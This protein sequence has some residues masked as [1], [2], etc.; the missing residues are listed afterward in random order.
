MPPDNELSFLDGMQDPN[1]APDGTYAETAAQESGLLRRMLEARE[2]IGANAVNRQAG[3]SQQGIV[4][5]EQAKTRALSHAE[6]LAAILDSQK[7][8]VVAKVEQQQVLDAQILGQR[9]TSMM[10]L[11]GMQTIDQ[12]GAAIPQ[13]MQAAKIAQARFDQAQKSANPIMEGL[14]QA[15][16]VKTD[17]VRA[18]E[19]ADAI[20]GESA[21]LQAD[22]TALINQ[23]NASNT[24]ANNVGAALNAATMEAGLLAQKAEADIQLAKLEE[25]KAVVGNTAWTTVYAASKD[26]LSQTQQVANM[27]ARHEIGQQSVAEKIAMFEIR[28]QRANQA[29]ELNQQRFEQ[30]TKAWEARMASAKTKEERDALEFQMKQEL[31]PYKLE[32]ARLN[33]QKTKG[34]ISKQLEQ[35]SQRL[36]KIAGA[37]KSSIKQL[38]PSMNTLADISGMPDANQQQVLAYSEGLI[39]QFEYAKEQEALLARAAAD[40][41]VEPTEANQKK[42]AELTSAVSEA[43][44]SL[45]VSQSAV[46]QYQLDMISKDNEKNNKWRVAEEQARN[47][48]GIPPGTKFKVGSPEAA[49]LST[50]TA[51][52]YNGLP[53]ATGAKTLIDAIALDSVDPNNPYKTSEYYS[54]TTRAL[55][56]RIDNAA[57]GY[58][59]ANAKAEASEAVKR[60]VERDLRL[61]SLGTSASGIAALPV[62]MKELKE[63][64]TKIPSLADNDFMKFV[65]NRADVSGT[66]LMQAVEDYVRGESGMASTLLGYGN[67]GT[68]AAFKA[69]Q[70]KANE[71]A[72]ALGVIYTTKLKESRYVELGIDAPPAPMVTT[73]D[74]GKF[75]LSD[76]ASLQEYLAKSAAIRMKPVFNFGN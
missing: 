50:T 63:V 23:M 64:A 61:N 70:R 28:E 19:E 75:I 54:A 12:L 2:A 47:L 66:S 11:G 8:G 40:L 74:E 31:Q 24:L 13:A 60:A 32:Q 9:N 1:L 3:I 39:K 34:V 41:Q 10:Q 25:A 26:Q 16:G 7:A 29:A 27:Q 42:V 36:S 59:G 35:S 44:A 58:K 6:R 71:A 56:D 73:Q 20:A 53:V 21:Q 67:E 43:N 45:Q 57:R 55:A 49:R 17:L 48:L 51:N 62:D 15:F 76:G 72:I 65:A 14:L 5:A 68:T 37:D 46:E 33:I 69:R 52:F 38:M 18:A 4:L 22:R 30:T